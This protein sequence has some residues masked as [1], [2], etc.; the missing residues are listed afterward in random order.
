M[1]GQSISAEQM[2]G[3][4]ATGIAQ[5]AGFATVPAGF[6]LCGTSLIANLAV[7]SRSLPPAAVPN[8]QEAL[9]QVYNLADTALGLQGIYSPTQHSFFNDYA[10]YIDNLVPAGSQKAPT[11]T[12]AGQLRMLQAGLTDANTQYNTDLN[13]ANTAWGQVSAANP[14]Q[15]DSFQSFLNGTTWGGIIDADNKKIAAIN[16]NIQTLL[17][18]IYGA[19]YLTIQANKAIVDNVRSAMQGSMGTGPYDMLVQATSGSLVVPAYSPSDLDKFSLWVDAIVFQHEGKV[20]TGVPP[21]VINFNQGIAKNVS[22]NTPYFKQTNWASNNF[23]FT[24]PGGNESAATQLDINTGDPGFSLQVQ[25]DDITQVS[26]SR[27][28]WFVPE[29]TASPYSYPNPNN[30]SAPAS[31]LIGMY[32]QIRMSLDPVS[33]ASAYSAYNTAGGFGFASFWVSASHT[34]NAS[35][36][37]MTATWDNTGNAVTIESSSVSPII[38]AMVAAPLP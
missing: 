22:V 24:S 35:T 1:P 37:S 7:S 14:G 4:Y 36:Q 23:F 26:L 27:G 28:P 8:M 29:L 34:Q 17:N 6:I 2:W 32:P 25:F 11:P 5:A 19:D 20:V 10:G 31:L 3:I 9:F 12:Q 38:L 15:Y 33:Y 18:K 21:A 30:L 16:S 13:S